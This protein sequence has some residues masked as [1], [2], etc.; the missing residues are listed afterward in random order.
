MEVAVA[1]VP[2]AAQRL[3]DRQ[4]E[5]IVFNTLRRSEEKA[6]LVGQ[7]RSLASG[8]KIID[9]SEQSEDESLDIGADA[10]LRMPLR[11]QELIETIR[12]LSG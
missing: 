8:V 10:H 2:D 1:H 11:L 7:F 9:V 6:Q 3:L 4:P 5:F 12:A